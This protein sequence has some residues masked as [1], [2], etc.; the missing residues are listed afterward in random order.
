MPSL[1]STHAATAQEKFERFFFVTSQMFAFNDF[2]FL[3][4]D[5]MMMIELHNEASSN[6]LEIIEMENN[7][8]ALSSSGAGPKIASRARREHILVSLE[9]IRTT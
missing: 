7:H 4:L 3:Q 9:L 5:G 6:W 1:C 8:R 2:E